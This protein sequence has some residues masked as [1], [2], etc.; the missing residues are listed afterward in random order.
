[1]QQNTILYWLLILVV[2]LYIK[3]NNKNYT[4]SQQL[5]LFVTLYILLFITIEFF[6]QLTNI[7]IW[8]QTERTINCYDWFEQYFSKKYDDEF[9]MTYVE[10]LF[11]GDYSLSIREATIKHFNY[12]YDTLGLKPGMKL[13]DLGCGIGTWMLFCKQRG[14]DVVGIT[15]SEEQANKIRE[16]KLEVIVGNYKVFNKHFVN[17]FDVVTLFGSTEHNCLNGSILGEKSKNDCNKKRTKIFKICNS[18]LK[19]NGKMFITTLVF[20]DKYNF[21]LS[22]YP[23]MYFLERHYGGRYSTYSNY[24][25]SLENSGFEIYYVKDTTKD[26]HWSSIADPDHFGAFKIK[27]NEDFFNKISYI[28]YGLLFDPFLLHHWMYYN[29]GAWMWQLGGYQKTPLTDEQVEC[30][31]CHNINFF[32]SKI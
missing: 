23:K 30:A 6:E 28:G 27:W 2:Y 3:N 1:M 25:K 29:I 9:K 19:E 31:P 16:K 12:V 4:K 21:K 20:N 10:S 7:Q 5:Y 17:G 11:D 18:Y 8:N 14:I 24:S 13:L 32:L 26:Y 15:L 22:D